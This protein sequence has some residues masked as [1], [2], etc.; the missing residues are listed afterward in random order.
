MVSFLECLV[1]TIAKT[2]YGLKHCY[3]LKK[4]KHIIINLHSKHLMHQSQQKSSD[5][6]SAEIFKKPLW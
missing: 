2:G 1:F 4:K 3:A 6:W 5:F